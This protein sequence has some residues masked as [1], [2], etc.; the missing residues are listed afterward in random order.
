[1]LPQAI[2]Q[3]KQSLPS[4]RKRADHDAAHLFTMIS[5]ATIN[6]R[7]L[8]G[9]ALGALVWIMASQPDG[10][11]LTVEAPPPTRA[12]ARQRKAFGN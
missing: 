4:M 11:P 5:N 9:N 2:H 1:M 10:A 3:I 12:T 7:G 6:A 8:S